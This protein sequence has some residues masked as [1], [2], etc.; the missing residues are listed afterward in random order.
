MSLS[1][2]DRSDPSLLRAPLRLRSAARRRLPRRLPIPRGLLQ[3]GRRARRRKSLPLGIH[4]CGRSR[5]RLFSRRVTVTLRA[6]RR[7]RRTYITP[8][9]DDV[10]VAQ[11]LLLL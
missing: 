9:D 2:R 4:I 10:L 6:V 11:G 7:T 5:R 3:L 1:L 8:A